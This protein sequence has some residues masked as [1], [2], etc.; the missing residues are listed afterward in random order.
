MAYTQS[1]YRTDVDNS[2]K[3]VTEFLFPELESHAHVRTAIQVVGKLLPEFESYFPKRKQQESQDKEFK[4]EVPKV[5]QNIW[6]LLFFFTSN[7]KTETRKKIFRYFGAVAVYS[8][9]ML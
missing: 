2:A 1:S 5:V 7:Y 4:E 9:I 3:T 8:Q 6:D